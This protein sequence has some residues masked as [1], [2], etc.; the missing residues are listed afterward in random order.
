MIT[1][2]KGK[3][4]PHDR[5]YLY[6]EK[7]ITYKEI[8]EL[9]KLLMENEDRIYPPPASG[10]KMLQDLIKKELLDE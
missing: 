3:K 5:I 4:G 10:R 8:I 7:A 2:K 1:W 9:L 6:N